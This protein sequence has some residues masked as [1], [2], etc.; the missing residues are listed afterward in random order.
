MD[1]LKLGR[2]IVE[3]RQWRVAARFKLF[4]SLLFMAAE[5]ECCVAGVQ[6]VR[7]QVLCSLAT[8]SA[9]TFL[10]VKQVRNALAALRK[11]GVIELRT[12]H[13]YTIVSICNYDSYMI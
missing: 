12:T 4:V 5:E 10:T 13:R 2:E 9:R 11:A 7:G 3:G 6:I 1:Y 8:L